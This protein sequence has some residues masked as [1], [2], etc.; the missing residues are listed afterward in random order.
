MPVIIDI[1]SVAVNVD[2]T[3]SNGLYPI[4]EVSRLTGINPV[5]LRAW[6]RRYGFIEPKRTNSGHRLYSVTDIETVR[7]VQGWIERGVS[8]SK[9]GE[10]LARGTPAIS[11]HEGVQ[12]TEYREW[13]LQISAAL[14]AFNEAQL[15]RLYG[16]IFSSYPPEVAFQ[17]ILMP[18]W[19]QL[20]KTRDEFGRTSEWLLLDGFL[21][22]R[23]QHRLQFQLQVAPASTCVVVVALADLCREL[24]LLVAGLLLS[25]ADRVIRVLPMGQPLDE[26]ALVC[27]KIQP[28]A[29]VV[30]AQRALTTAH[31]R[32]LLKL[33]QTLDCSTLL[34]GEA[35]NVA[36]PA[37]NDSSIGC[38]GHDARLMNQRLDAEL[39]G[40]VAF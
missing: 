9:V 22:G 5:T 27:E 21:R 36:Q 32:R 30:F 39:K 4:R 18:L 16:Q 13:Q 12:S 6:E 8:V 11:R 25:R 17:D 40:H 26:L 34:A 1:E 15:E 35:A 20:F 10:L 33:A 31:H 7:R 19:H 2:T 29:V 24:E 14:T 28:A 23:V 3:E 38:L 37:L